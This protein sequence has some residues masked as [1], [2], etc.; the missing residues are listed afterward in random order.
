MAPCLKQRL[1]LSLLL[2][3]ASVATS[4]L[5]AR[6]KALVVPVT[7]DAVTLQYTTVLSQRTPLVPLRLVLDLG[8][9]FLWIDCDSGYSSSTYR[10]ARC[11]SAQCSLASA[12]DCGSC[13]SP[14]RPGCFN[15]TCGLTPDNSVT[16]TATSGQ[17]GSDI[18]SL[19]STDGSNPGP[20]ATVNNLLFVCAPTFLLNGLAKGAVGMAGLGRARVG[21][22]SLLASSF[23]F[24]R[25]FAICL[26][27]SSGVAFFGPGPYSLLPPPGT[28]Y[29]QSLQYTPLHVNPVSTTSAFSQ[30]DPSTE[31][32]IGV[33][34]ITVGS[35]AVPIN[36]SLLKIDS[37][38]GL[39][40]TKI[41]TVDPYTVLH[42]SIYTSFLRVY[43]AEAVARNM[44]TVASVKPF[45][46][47]FSSAGV[48]GTRVGAAVPYITLNLEGQNADWTI[49][50]SNSIV[51][52]SD[53]VLCL[54]FVDGGDSARTSIVIGGY[55]LEDNLL[56]FDL[57]RSRF[58]FSSTLLGSRTTCANF[59][60][61][62][63]A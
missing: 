2:F 15:N 62:S 3:A 49:T 43:K 48:F 63:N 16:H 37:S 21:L 35:T 25:K 32:F 11:R 58:G 54:G 7:K 50:G 52:V 31:Y 24:A 10:P 33:K 5:A 59:N 22:P 56:E 41:S 29:S 18:L 13:S 57:A 39:G 19:P 9:Q 55:Q 42:T 38:T 36:S 4:S 28:D 1:F 26:G 27:S 14:S 34:L 8:G 30:G 47:C 53:D 12:S 60:F 44:T 6:P 20:D 23:S 51:E 61:T 45:G 17:L 46:L 40:G